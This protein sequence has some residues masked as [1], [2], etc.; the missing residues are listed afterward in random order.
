LAGVQVGDLI[1]VPGRG[2]RL[3]HTVLASNGGGQLYV[4][5]LKNRRART[6][7]LVA[8]LHAL[9]ERRAAER[10]ATDWLFAAPG[11]GPLRESSWKR[12][13]RW[14]DAVAKLGYPTVRVHDLRHTSASLWLA[15]G[16]DP[17]VVQAVLGHFSAVM[18]MDVYGHLIA[19]N[20]WEAADRLGGTGSF[21]DGPARARS[22]GNRALSCGNDGSR[23]WESNPRATHYEIFLLELLTSLF[24][25]SPRV[26]AMTGS[27]R[28]VSVAGSPRP[29]V[30]PLCPGYAHLLAPVGPLGQLA[31]VCSRVFYWTRASSSTAARPRIDRDWSGRARDASASDHA[32][33]IDLPKRPAAR[34]D[35][36]AGQRD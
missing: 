33:L 35:L 13:V 16:A 7:P 28:L 5:A 15:S 34:R 22:A 6:V 23:L 8:E 20:L 30:P 27:H 31:R 17:K 19:A 18:T 11:G 12:A 9:V 32:D 2:L 29:R 26:A 1:T 3:Q 21:R 25:D 4:D 10:S 36:D 24:V 14:S